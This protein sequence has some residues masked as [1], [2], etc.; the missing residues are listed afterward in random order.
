MERKL[1]PSPGMDPN[2]IYQQV[3]LLQTREIRL[4][5]LEKLIGPPRPDERSS[6]PAAVGA[7][8]EADDK[9]SRCCS[10]VG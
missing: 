2:A 5:R 7:W 3:G 9:E 6:D 4:V 8:K 1:F 10:V